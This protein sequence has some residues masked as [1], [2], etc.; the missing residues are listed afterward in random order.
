MG[1]AVAIEYI[2]GEA[3]VDGRFEQS[4]RGTIFEIVLGDMKDKIAEES[5]EVMIIGAMVTT[6]VGIDQERAHSQETIMVIELEA[7]QQ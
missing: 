6:E 2:L 4:Y 7:K 5:I 3:I 1:Q